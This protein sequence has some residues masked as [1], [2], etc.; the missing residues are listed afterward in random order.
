[1]IQRPASAE[2][3]IVIPAGGEVLLRKRSCAGRP[4]SEAF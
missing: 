1:M 2:V 4:R 3:G